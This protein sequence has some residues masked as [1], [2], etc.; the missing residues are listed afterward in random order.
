MPNYLELALTYTPIFFLVS[1]FPGSCML[2]A[3][4]TSM[5]Y[6]KKATIFLGFGEVIGLALMTFCVLF[7]IEIISEQSPLAQR[8]FQYLSFC[9]IG[10][11][12]L[13]LIIKQQTKIDIDKENP[14]EI[15]FFIKGFVTAFFNPK[16][17]LFLT[18][19]I[20]GFINPEI[21]FNINAT[22]LITITIIV[23]SFCIMLYVVFGHSVAEIFS[24]KKIMFASGVM[25]LAFAL[26]SIL[27][28][29]IIVVL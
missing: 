15:S 11:L 26:F 25:L 7:G 10:Y 29:S 20:P 4:S 3:L 2:L 13:D 28:T 18:L 21:N 27:Y 19:F 23:E 16:G 6:G 12:G 9:Y 22:L 1:V 17:W 24:S 8:L 5:V 14:E